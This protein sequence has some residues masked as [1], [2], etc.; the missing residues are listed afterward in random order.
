MLEVHA[1][2]PLHGRTDEEPWTLG[3]GN[4]A[5]AHA[6]AGAKFR[7]KDRCHAWSQLWFPFVC[8]AFVPVARFWC[9][10]LEV[11]AATA[12]GALWRGSTVTI[13]GTMFAT[14][15]AAVGFA[16]ELGRCGARP[17]ERAHDHGRR[18]A[19]VIDGATYTARHV[20]VQLGYQACAE[21]V[22]CA[23]SRSRGCQRALDFRRAIER[24]GDGGGARTRS[25]VSLRTR[26]R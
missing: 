10:N 5:L 23:R 8:A 9:F 24:R 2:S 14:R 22:L 16:G 21:F 1:H 19:I 15:G 13:A 20:L 18:S 6:E 7:L 17:R 3:S 26:R 4:L 11:I 25:L 12:F